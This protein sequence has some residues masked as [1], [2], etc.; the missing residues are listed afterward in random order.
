MHN[1]IKVVDVREREREREGW[2]FQLYAWN[3]EG[4]TQKAASSSHGIP[5]IEEL[6][7]ATTPPFHCETI[8]LSFSLY[9]SLYI[10]VG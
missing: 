3:D 6:L 10:F 7:A 2:V 9:L 1:K 4:G 5:W 8:N